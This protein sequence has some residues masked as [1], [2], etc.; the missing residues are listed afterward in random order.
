M[1]AA[2]L[3]ECLPNIHEALGFDLGTHKAGGGSR[4]IRSVESTWIHREF[5]VTWTTEKIF[6]Y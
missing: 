5:K 4:R 3:V 2:H 1:V 6:L